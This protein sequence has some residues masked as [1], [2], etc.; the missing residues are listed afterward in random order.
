MDKRNKELLK[1]IE[2]S[3]EQF[4]STNPEELMREKELG[5]SLSFK[6][7]ENIIL[8]IIELFSQVKM[9]HLQ[10]VPF[11]HLQEFHSYL[12]D[13]L[14]LFSQMKEFDIKKGNPNQEKKQITQRLINSY[15][16]YYSK[17]IPILTNQTIFGNEIS[18]TEKDLAQVVTESR[19]LKSEA[20]NVYSEIKATL[21]NAK[22]AVR[23]IGISKY[24]VI[25]QDEAKDYSRIART[26]LAWTFVCIFLVVAASLI[27]IVYFPT[28]TNKTAIIVQYTISKLVVLSALFY[29]MALCNKNYRAH[30]HNELINKHRQN[31]LSTFETFSNASGS[32]IQTKNAVLLEATRTI[33]SNQQTGYTSGNNDQEPSNKIIEIFKNITTSGVKE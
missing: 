3:I 6:D 1:N 29:A 33:F 2:T 22:E 27:F 11:L 32:D 15:E 18:Q 13:A 12:L 16:T 8:N 28:E 14:S 17:T 26:W 31:A 23:D 9:D 10:M 30:K 21:E 4:K 24:T 5:S 25:F 19:R 7:S 20:D